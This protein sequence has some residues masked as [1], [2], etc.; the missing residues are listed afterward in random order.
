MK[1]LIITLLIIPFLTGFSQ[2]G[3]KG[4][5][6][7]GFQ[8]G[9]NHS[10]IYGNNVAGNIL[11]I[12]P[13]YEGVVIFGLTN[14]LSFKSGF[15][16]QQK[17]RKSNVTMFDDTGV[18]ISTSFSFK[19]LSSYLVF[20]FLLNIKTGN[21]VIFFADFG[22]YYGLFLKGESTLE[23]PPPDGLVSS[24]Y[25]YK[26]SDYGA[27]LGLGVKIPLSEKIRLNISVRNE[28]GLVN[29][30]KTPVYNNGTI[31]NNSTLALLGLSYR[32]N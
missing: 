31:K 28:L 32:L 8:G 27:V 16:Y 21:K 11:N 7:L 18:I 29:V 20:P 12:N 25:D 15:S 10:L 17:G 3:N 9:V 24:S 19:G 14:T 22:F 23:M 13:T 2:N 26:K 1:H 4:S 6:E 30:S 5:I